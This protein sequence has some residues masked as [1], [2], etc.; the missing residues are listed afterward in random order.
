[1]GCTENCTRSPFP[2]TTLQGTCGIGTHMVY[3][4]FHQYMGQDSW[5]TD[6]YP[7]E[8]FSSWRL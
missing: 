3:Y 8:F 1:M 4:C 7:R 6:Y 2:L 5:F